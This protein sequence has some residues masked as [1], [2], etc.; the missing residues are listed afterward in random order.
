MSRFGAK[1]GMVLL[2]ANLLD[3]GQARLCGR[4]EK[5]YMYHHREAIQY[6]S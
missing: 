5:V 1:M 4:I 6:L 2:C 3:A